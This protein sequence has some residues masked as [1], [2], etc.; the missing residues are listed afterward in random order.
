MDDRRAVCVVGLDVIHHRRHR[1]QLHLR[2][3]QVG[4]EVV[5]P[6]AGLEDDLEAL[7]GQLPRQGQSRPRLRQILY[8]PGGLRGVEHVLQDEVSDSQGLRRPRGKHRGDD[9]GHIVRAAEGEVVGEIGLERLARLGDE[10]HHLHVLLQVLPDGVRPAPVD[11]AEP[12]EGERVPGDVDGLLVHARQ[13]EDVLRSGIGADEHRPS[14]LPHRAE[15]LRAVDGHPAAIWHSPPVLSEVR[16]A[17]LRS[18]DGEHIEQAGRGQLSGPLKKQLHRLNPVCQMGADMRAHEGREPV[19]GAMA[20]PGDEQILLGAKPGA[21]G[22]VHRPDLPVLPAANQAAGE[23]QAEV[24]IGDFLRH[25]PGPPLGGDAEPV[26]RLARRLVT[27]EHD[28]AVAMLA[29]HQLSGLG[30]PGEVDA[31]DGP[32]LG[33]QQAPPFQVMDQA[34]EHVGAIAR[35]QAIAEAQAPDVVLLNPALH[36]VN[37]PRSLG[38]PNR[39]AHLRPGDDRMVAAV[40]QELADRDQPERVRVYHRPHKAEDIPIG[41]RRR[42]REPLVLRSHARSHGRLWNASQAGIS[43]I[44]TVTLLSFAQRSDVAK[45]RKALRRTPPGI[46]HHF[47]ARRSI[48][49]EI[50]QG[51][52]LSRI[53]WTALFPGSRRSEMTA[54]GRV[55]SARNSSTWLVPQTQPGDHII[56]VKWARDAV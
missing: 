23:S 36:Q 11:L 8:P 53:R 16:L 9:I 21:S 55:F 41:H 49:Q 13:R 38:S 26:Q 1:R 40:L 22:A 5:E 50:P 46:A 19:L 54:A 12:P 18:A 39:L 30:Q 20:H 34:A 51:D 28:H 43:C 42:H 25:L 27:V 33:G 56:H 4:G 14:R 48:V 6:G 15:L 2:L 47:S 31:R 17:E 7:V 44:R 32:A 3:L 52:R 10:A 24:V 45:L 29:R 37:A 35:V